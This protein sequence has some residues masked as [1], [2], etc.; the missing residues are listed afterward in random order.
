[1]I[2]PSDRDYQEAKRLKLSRERLR[3][4]YAE[5]ADWIASR[6]N[7]QVL[8]VR[9]DKVIPDNR[10]R[11]S[12][13]LDSED[14][15]A[16]FKLSRWVADEAKVNAIREHF[17]ELVSGKRDRQEGCVGLFV[18]FEAFE[19]VARIEA[20]EKVDEPEIAN[21]KRSLSNPELWEISRCFDTA[22]YFSYTN[23]QLSGWEQQ[24]LREVYEQA[25][26]RVVS[27][28][29]QFGYLRRR[30]IEVLFDSKENLDKNYNGNWFSYYR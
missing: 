12:V 10:P 20:N 28:Y 4:P 14:D 17:L 3:S 30:G 2:V 11:L 21:L 25:Y 13:V 15:A 26:A 7:V 27:K 24:G 29:D 19:T 18:I 16:A 1:M 5:M 6:Y 8:N 9:Y 23:K 22:T